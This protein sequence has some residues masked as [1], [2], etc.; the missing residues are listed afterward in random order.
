MSYLSTEAKQV[1]VAKAL[2]KGANRRELAK[3]NNVGYSSL[4]R[5][6]KAYSSGGLAA[7]KYKTNRTDNVSAKTRLQHLLATE[8]LD[9]AALGAYCREHG[10]YST[11]ITR[12]KAEFMTEPS[13]T[14]SS[15][16]NIE[17]KALREENKQLKRDLNRKEKALAETAA[18]LVLKKK[19][20]YLWGEDEDV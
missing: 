13:K 16:Q 19:A 4:S 1:L 17:L 14:K 2:K 9:E 18:L 20:T 11:Q 5:W 7:E 12:W 15:K 8:S 10:L 6:I 3:Q